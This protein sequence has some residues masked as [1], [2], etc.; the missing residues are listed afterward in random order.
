MTKLNKEKVT[1]DI[2]LMFENKRKLKELGSEGGRLYPKNFRDVA[3]MHNV[4]RTTIQ[5]FNDRNLKGAK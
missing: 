4:S 1:K 3:K 5:S 2:K